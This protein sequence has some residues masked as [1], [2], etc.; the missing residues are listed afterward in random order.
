MELVAHLRFYPGVHIDVHRTEDALLLET[1]V[2]SGKDYPETLISVSN[3][4][5]CPVACTF[6]SVDQFARNV[7]ADEYL[8]Q[9]AVVLEN[10][11][12][13]PWLDPEKSV[14]VSFTRAGEPL[15]NKNTFDGLVK[16]ADTFAPEFKFTSMMP[17]SN[18]SYSLLE[19]MSDFLQ[20]YIHPFQFNV[21]MHTSSEKR[22]KEI[23]PYSHLMG[24]DE[25]ASF[26]EDWVKKLP[27]RKVNLSFVM[28]EDN[29]INLG[30][31]KDIFDPDYF[32]LRFAL[33]LPVTKEALAN[34][35]P[36]PVQRMQILTEQ[37]H[38]LGYGC[39]GSVAKHIERTWH[40]S[41]GSAFTMYRA[42]LDH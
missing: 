7:T 1:A 33:Y 42:S 34:H 25:I 32:A 28:M 16:I 41:P 22:R 2:Y 23:I 9:V 19:K 8:G 12:G 39:I 27:R 3:Q 37:A 15:L 18:L 40:T 24:Y 31:I 4:V 21:S 36:S 5:G 30:A 11:Y 20:S 38:N 13:V 26:G 17:S 6:C 29:P 14:K 10:N 35:D